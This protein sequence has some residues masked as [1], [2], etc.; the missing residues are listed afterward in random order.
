MTNEHIDLGKLGALLRQQRDRTGELEKTVKDLAKA[1]SYLSFKEK[2]MRDALKVTPNWYGWEINFVAGAT[3][4]TPVT[5]QT[6]PRGYFFADRIHMSWRVADAGGVN[7]GHWQPI[8]SDNSSIMGGVLASGAAAVAIPA[9][10]EG[11]DFYWEYSEGSASLMRMN[12]AIP[13]TVLYRGD[14]D[15]VI[16]GSDGWQPSTTVTFFITPIGTGPLR[17]GVFNI[18]VGGSQCYQTLM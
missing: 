2:T 4:R 15:G 11:M 1:Q 16:P 18:S 12:I 14:G 13:G 17:A 10:Y 3:Q 5:I 7:N 9:G 8:S 6:D